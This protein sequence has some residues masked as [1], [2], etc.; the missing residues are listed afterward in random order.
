MS[1]TSAD[2]KERAKFVFVE[3]HGYGNV[4]RVSG[5]NIQEF[6][7]DCGVAV[8]AG[9]RLG[10]GANGLN[11]SE[12][13]EAFALYHERTDPK[14]PER[15]NGGFDSLHHHSWNWPIAEEVV[16]EF[17][18]VLTWLRWRLE[19]QAGSEKEVDGG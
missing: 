10:P 16:K 17:E 9:G 15:W 1:K 14:L 4:L 2:G 3:E 12:I 19:Q 13:T 11:E 8:Y 5:E 6:C 18:Q 7:I